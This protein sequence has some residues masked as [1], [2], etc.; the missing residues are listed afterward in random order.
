[1]E[2]NKKLT[3]HFFFL[4][5]GVLATLIA[6]VA[7]FLNLLFATLGHAFPDVLVAS[8]QY[9]YSTY[10]FENMRTPLAILIIVFPVFLMLSRYWLKAMRR[11]MSHW[12]TIIRKWLLYLVL[13]LASLTVIADL[14]T[15]VRYFVS[16]EITIRFILKVIAVL[17]VAGMVGWYYVRQVQ[18]KDN[19][20]INGWI[21]IKSCV[22][23]LA[24]IVWA[25]VVMG[26]PFT[27]RDLRL[28][29]RRIEDIQSIQWQIISFW[30]QK[31]KL[32]TTLDELSNPISS[33]MIPRDPEFQKGRVYEYRKIDT[34]KFEL[35][36]TFTLPMPEG[37]VEYGK[38][39]GYGGG[40]VERDMAVSMPYPG[41]GI[42]GESWDHEGGR[43][44]HERTIDPDIYPPFP[45]DQ[46]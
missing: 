32:P 9:G 38:Y 3:P 6:S 37:W 44:C 11:E 4:S 26:S 43:T 40:M 25:F 8:Y 10:N 20:K 39:Y 12:D 23:V 14:V 13:F 42:P 17:I 46:R 29:Q 21:A 27:Q 16:G 33:Y 45:K 41:P 7:S 34:M 24:A 19:P 5:I 31:E 1:M 18:G 28:D 30:Q 35:C 2:P 22:L 36:A 15:L